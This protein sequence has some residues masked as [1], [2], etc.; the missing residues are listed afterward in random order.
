MF[1]IQSK[2][3]IAVIP[4]AWVLLRALWVKILPPQGHRLP[5]RVYPELFSEID[6]LSK[7]LNSLKI[8]EVILDDSLNAAVV[9]HPRLGVLGWYKNYLLI[10]YQLMLTLSPE[11][12]R[13]VL[14]H[15]FGHISRNHGRFE[16][17][18]YRVRLIW[19]RIMETF[20]HQDSLGA[21]LMRWFFDW[22]SPRFNAYSFALARRNEYEADA[23]SAVLTSPE[24]AT[25]AL[26]NSYTTAPYLEEEYW[27][28]FYRAADEHPEPT[29]APFKGLIAFL[30][31]RQYNREETL[32]RIKTAMCVETH[33]ADTHPCLKDRVM[34]LGAS[35]Q[36]PVLPKIDAAEAWFGAGNEN[37]IRELDQKWFDENAAYW[38][39]RYSYVQDARDKLQK[40]PQKQLAQLSD[41][42]L[43]EY[44]CITNE[45]VSSNAAF[46][47]FEAYKHRHPAD[48]DSAYYLGQV[49]LERNDDAGLA[50]LRT[51]GNNPV[52]LE[53]VAYT[54]YNYLKAQGKEAEA[55]DWWQE[56]IKQN[57]V[58]VKAQIEREKVDIYDRFTVPVLEDRLLEELTARLRKQ[59]DVDKAWLAQKV[60]HYHPDFPA[61]VLAFRARRFRW[62]SIRKASRLAQALDMEIALIV[63]CTSGKTK[64]VANMAIEAGIRVV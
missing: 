6:A 62:F 2:L 4:A 33:Y 9:Q 15:E 49:L 59:D 22:Y 47:L 28:R 57:E 50:H 20:D 52:L 24:V 21:A 48:P 8:H 60:V 36:I 64:E 32:D 58:H 55:D 13:S 44:A 61:Y 11:E 35:P 54:G 34:A 23:V 7:K 3:V 10:G 43:W 31:T 51:A 53:D 40:Y 1:L 56:S 37:I 17:W 12:M 30:K 25:R 39:E 38:N 16:G 26:V 45:F 19:L 27:D 63:V 46:P 29:H 18:I 14:A 41:Q 42:E 5:R